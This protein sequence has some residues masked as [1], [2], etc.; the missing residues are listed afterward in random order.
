MEKL[1]SIGKF[2]EYAD[3]SRRTLIYYD[4]INLFKPIELSEKGYRMYSIKQ[5]EQFG[6]ICT[7]KNLG[8]SLD[9]IKKY[10][11]KE[12]PETLQKD[13]LSLRDSIRREMSELQRM[14]DSLTTT[15]WR[16]D[17][18]KNSKKGVIVSEQLPAERFYASK[19]NDSCEGLNYFNDFGDFYHSL[20]KEEML[21]GF[22]TGYVILNNERNKQNFSKSPYR[23]IRMTNQSMIKNDPSQSIIIKPAGRYLKLFTTNSEEEISKALCLLE[24]EVKKNN[25]QIIGDYWIVN[26]NEHLVSDVNKQLIEIQVNVQL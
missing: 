22:P 15:L 10:I 6:L 12:N 14:E 19:K 13:I 1:L 11:Y 7:L 5:Y 18:V 3:I 17:Y 25:D 24:E 26:W 2:A 16:Q 8:F 23:F 9:L 21:T 20:D 4:E